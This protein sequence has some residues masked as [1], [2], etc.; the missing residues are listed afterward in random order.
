MRKGTWTEKNEKDDA[1]YFLKV[2]SIEII[3]VFSGTADVNRHVPSVTGPLFIWTRCEKLSGRM[4]GT[5]NLNILKTMLVV[6][7]K[8]YE[9]PL[10]HME[11]VSTE[12]GFAASEVKTLGAAIDDAPE[13]DYGTF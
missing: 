11:Q 10:L 12:C 5:N 1:G 4:L 2:S 3:K 6:Q 7:S 9:T 13:S 8:T